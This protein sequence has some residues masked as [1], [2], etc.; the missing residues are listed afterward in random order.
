MFLAEIPA[1][2]TTKSTKSSV[3]DVDWLVK[4]KPTIDNLAVHTKKIQEVRGWF[5]LYQQEKEIHPCRI[6]TIEGPTGSAKTTC[7][8]L[9]A[10]ENNYEICEYINP[11]DIESELFQEERK[12][13]VSVGNQ[14]EKFLDFLLK[15]SRFGSLFSKKNRLL[16][17]KD[18]PNVFLKQKEDFWEILK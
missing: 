13:F 15:S 8:T 2:D 9:I 12:R 18:L 11:I 16:L 10:K 17:V 5:E 6:L 4:F 3:P 1:I 7:L 14:V